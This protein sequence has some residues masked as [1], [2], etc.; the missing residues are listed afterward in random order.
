L[1]R[2][3]TDLGPE[4]FP[5]VTVVVVVP[6]SVWTPLDIVAL[7]K[8]LMAPLHVMGFGVGQIIVVAPSTD[9]QYPKWEM[10]ILTDFGGT[11]T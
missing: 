7:R 11:S 2:P 4:Q 8:Q 9:E 10:M 6:L 3:P 1:T 5:L